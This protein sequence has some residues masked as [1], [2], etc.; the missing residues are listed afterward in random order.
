MKKYTIQQA[1]E[2]MKTKTQWYNKSYAGYLFG[3]ALQGWAIAFGEEASPYA[4]PY[5]L[6]FQN[7][8]RRDH[9]D[10]FW[11]VELL[12]EKRQKLL[13]AAKADKKFASHFLHNWKK[14]RKSFL[15]YWETLVDTSFDKL[16]ID[17]IRELLTPLGKQYVEYARLSYIADVFLTDSGPDWFEQ[18]IKKEFVAKATPEVIATL[19]VPVYESFINK[20]EMGKL[21]IAKEILEGKNEKVI[22]RACTALAHEFFWVRVGYFSYE[23]LTAHEIRAEAVKESGQD[24]LK[25]IN[26]KIKTAKSR[27][28]DN[29][30]KKLAL[31]KKLKTSSDLARVI[32]VAEIFTHIQDERKGGV[33]RCNLI[34]FEALAATARKLK[35]DPETLFYL[36]PPEFLS[37]EEFDNLDWKEIKDRRDKGAV[38]VFYDKKIHILPRAQYEKELPIEHFFKLLTVVQEVRGSIAFAGREKGIVRVVRTMKDIQNFKE[39]EILVANQ[40]TPEYMLAIKKAAAIVT[41]QGGITCHAA[42]IA[43]ELKKPCIIGTKSATKDLHD[44]DEVEVDAEKGI[45]KILKSRAH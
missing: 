10:W 38:L 1:L 44:G 6:F 28:A 26:E 45:V 30:K 36:T 22:S 5:G 39:G 41:D 37:K 12:I 21:K 15:T 17:Q 16:S 43:R 3:L 9:W 8:V 27:I 4:V 11:D 25:E 34:F 19:S 14:T 32:E 31:M 23:R 24:G 42:I 20:F 7:H 40:T 33:L 13:A 35:L 29:K 2:N 18:I